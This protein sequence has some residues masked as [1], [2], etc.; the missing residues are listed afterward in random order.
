MGVAA[1]KVNQNLPNS[2]FLPKNATATGLL[3][4]DFFEL[5]R[6]ICRTQIAGVGFI[7]LVSGGLDRK[8]VV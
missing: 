6:A 8:S 2:G 7:I 4:F 5:F 1:K 3:G